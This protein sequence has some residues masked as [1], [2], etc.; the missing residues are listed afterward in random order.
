MRNTF[1]E[2]M[3]EVGQR[4]PKLVVMVGDISHFALQPFAKAAPGRFYNIGI[5][6]PTMV[7][8]SA[9]VAATGL[10]PVTHTIAPF[11][12][13]RSLEQIKLDYCYQNLGG[14][15]VSVGGAFDY[16]QLGCSHHCYNDLALLNGLPNTEV[17][18]PASPVE[19][20]VLFEETYR[21]GKLTYFRLPGT[22]HGVEFRR[23]QIKYAKGIKVKEGK[24]ITLIG[25]GP[26]LK[27]IMNSLAALSDQR[28]DAEV[29]YLP[30]L[31]PFDI[32]L[33]QESVAR[34]KKVI[35]L[36]EHARVGGFGDEVLRATAGRGDYKYDFIQIPDVF[37]RA[38]GH[39]DEHLENLGFTTEN[40]VKKALNLCKAMN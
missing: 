1:A 32:E 35:V 38:Y 39:Y 22:Q 36:E 8:M 7:S 13:E 3:L 14:T 26:R 12:I 30:M 31:K 18:Y 5:L 11:L 9:G 19:F 25:A 20:K 2:T 16:S 4:D 37:Q 15:L 24:D 21:N 23:D 27:T 40:L 17:V 6:E 28:I 34:T 10:Y 33:V 29:L